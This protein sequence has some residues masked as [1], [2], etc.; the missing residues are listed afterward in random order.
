MSGYLGVFVR[1]VAL[2]PGLQTVGEIAVGGMVL[3]RRVPHKADPHMG[4]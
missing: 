2:T 4:A 1:T 3:A